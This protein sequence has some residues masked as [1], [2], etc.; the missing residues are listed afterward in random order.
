MGF[1]PTPDTVGTPVSAGL[2][3]VTL[4]QQEMLACKTGHS[5]LSPS[6]LSGVSQLLTFA[7]NFY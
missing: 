2:A 7:T 4:R 5:C 3:A 1:Y 6:I